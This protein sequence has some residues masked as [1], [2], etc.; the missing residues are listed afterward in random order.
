MIY[1]KDMLAQYNIPDD[2]AKKVNNGEWTL[3]VLFDL[4]SNVSGDIDGVEGK[5]DGDRFGFTTS[6]IFNIR[7]PVVHVI[8]F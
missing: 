3:D 6:K 1:S 8:Y 4:A 5:S 7:F 2:L